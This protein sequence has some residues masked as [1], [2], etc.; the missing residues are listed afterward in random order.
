MQTHDKALDEIRKK[1]I[2]DIQNEAYTKNGFIP[3]Y[4]ANSKSKII[5]IGQAPGI[6]AQMNET[7]WNDKSGDRLRD[8][9]GVS[10]E[11][12]YNVDNFGLIPMDF[13]YPGKGQTG[14]LPPRK[15]FAEK[16]HPLILEHLKDVRLI[17]LVGTYA[18]SFYLGKNMKGSLTKT[19]ASYT[20]YLPLY[21]PLAHPSP[22]N[23][24]WRNKN[25][26]FENDVIPILKK[27]VSDILT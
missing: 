2:N 14:D 13:Y 4:S 19:V 20:E 25:P 26:W 8:W 3:I 11:V 7:T 15:G 6:K 9:L 18:Q 22:L 17:L 10:K 16:W 23:F 21:F 1:I 24:R 27:F 5:I 12:F